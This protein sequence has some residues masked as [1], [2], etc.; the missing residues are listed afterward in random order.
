MK[1][2]FDLS[3]LSVSFLCKDFL[4]FLKIKITLAGSSTQFENFRKY[5]SDSNLVKF[6]RKLRGLS[7]SSFFEA[8]FT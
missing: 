7:L 3:F 4:T 2:F 6:K 8:Q 5:S 1:I